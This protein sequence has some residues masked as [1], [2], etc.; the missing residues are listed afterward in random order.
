MKK[1]ILLVLGMVFL[2][3]CGDN[4]AVKPENRESFTENPYFKSE[5]FL[6]QEDHE[7][8]LKLIKDGEK[9]SFLE[10]LK[11][12]FD[13]GKGM[14]ENVINDKENMEYVEKIEKIAKSK[15]ISV[16]RGGGECYI[17]FTA[18]DN[19]NVFGKAGK[20]NIVVVSFYYS[21]RYVKNVENYP[22]KLW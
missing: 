14:W 20:Y 19:S 6:N 13:W 10:A 17:L 12:T 22:F 5:E 1:I 4:V 21:I 15:F 18:V 8:T 3:N 11:N 16:R 7:E 2:T 9:N